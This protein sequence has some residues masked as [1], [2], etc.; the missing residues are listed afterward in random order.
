M[1]GFKAIRAH[2]PPSHLNPEEYTLRMEDPWVIHRSPFLF[3]DRG[4]WNVS[5]GFV[6]GKSIKGSD[7]GNSSRIIEPAEI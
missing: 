3:N 1:S 7:V 4:F 2:I 6:I 5:S